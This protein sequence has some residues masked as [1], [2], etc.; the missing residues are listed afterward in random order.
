MGVEKRLQTRQV[1]FVEAVDAIIADGGIDGVVLGA[2]DAERLVQES[3]AEDEGEDPVV[4]GKGIADEQDP[5]TAGQ[6][7]RAERFEDMAD[8]GVLLSDPPLAFLFSSGVKWNEQKGN[9]GKY[10]RGADA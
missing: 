4:G 7:F 10:D 3:E 5:A 8:V 9:G 2:V 1:P 6:R